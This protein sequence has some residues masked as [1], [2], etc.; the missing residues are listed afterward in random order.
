MARLHPL[1]LEAGHAWRHCPAPQ[2]SQGD[3]SDRECAPPR[4]GRGDR[5]VSSGPGGVGPMSKAPIRRAG[6]W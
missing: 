5:D 4:R 1:P 3:G 2:R 6:G